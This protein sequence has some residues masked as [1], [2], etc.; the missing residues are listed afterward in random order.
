MIAAPVL[1]VI[2]GS[3]IAILIPAELPA[4]IPLLIV[5]LISPEIAHAISQIHLPVQTSKTESQQIQVD[6]LARRT[7]AYFERFVGP[8]DHWLPPDHFQE[9]PFGITAHLSL[10][11][12]SSKTFPNLEN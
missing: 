5:W 1:A 6:R 9:K 7:W 8:D 2:L 11:R 12:L 3:T 4:L 10:Y